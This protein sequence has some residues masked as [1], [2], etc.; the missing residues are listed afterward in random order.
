MKILIIQT[1]F[2]GDVILTT[3]LIEKL[4][5]HDN[6]CTIDFLLRK[7]NE[8][9][10]E[11]HPYL[12]KILIFNKKKRK[13][14]NLIDLIK[15][16]RARSYDYVINVQRFFS[17]GL[18]TGLSAAKIKIG[19]NKNP[20]SFLYTYS[21]KHH[22]FPKDQGYHEV[23]RNLAL[24]EKMAD[25]AF[26]RPRL[27]PSESDYQKVSMKEDYICIA[28]ASIWFTKQFPM[29]KWCELIDKLPEKYLIFLIGGKSDFELC[30]QILKKAGTKKIENWSGKLTFLQSAAFIEKAKMT[31]ANDSAPVHLASAMNAPVTAIYCSTVPEFGFGPLSDISY[32]IETDEKLTCR[33]CGLHGKVR[34]PEKH[35]RCSEI[36]IDRIIEKVSAVLN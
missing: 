18:I 21:Y 27:Y 23:D 31:F 34:C 4:K 1:A 6:N 7:G 9:L 2:I 10:L 25:N 36:N 19:F 29:H 12:N 15:I 11:N 8:S 14:K 22:I 24:I 20:L 13:F 35:F 3:P 5:E 32:I 33:P 16:I 28:P 17:T 26:I 30:D